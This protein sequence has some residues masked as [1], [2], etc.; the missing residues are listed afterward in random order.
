MFPKSIYPLTFFGNQFQLTTPLGALVKVSLTR[1]YLNYIRTDVKIR[2][3]PILISH[4]G[5][6]LGFSSKIRTRNPDEIRVVEQSVLI[7]M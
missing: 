1:I 3:F 7:T 4:I 2:I 5:Q 6:D